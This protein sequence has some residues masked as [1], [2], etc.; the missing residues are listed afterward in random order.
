MVGPALSILFCTTNPHK[1]REVAAIFAPLEIVVLG[2]DSLP[3]ALREMPEPV[4]DGA[5]FGENARIKARYYAERCG[6]RCLAEDSGLEVDALGGAPGVHSARYS[7]EGGERAE[8]DQANNEKLLRALAGVPEA[9]R[10]ARFV[11]AMALADPDGSVV[12]EARGTFE[13]IIAPAPRGEGGFGYDPLLWLPD[14]GKTSAELTAEEK[15]ARSHRGVATRAIA[16]LI[17]GEAR[18]RGE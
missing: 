4:E 7:G 2:L 15:N 17:R 18:S 14:V 3:P 9:Q 13:G 11:C 1:V 16:A 12:A 5:T 10:T 6:T 8:R